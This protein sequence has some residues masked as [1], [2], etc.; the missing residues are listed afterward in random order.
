ML[1]CAICVGCAVGKTVIVDSATVMLA[2]VGNVLVV[3]LL[4]I[5]NGRSVIR[6]LVIVVVTAEVVVD[7]VVSSDDCGASGDVLLCVTDAVGTAMLVEVLSTLLDNWD[8]VV[9]ESRVE[10]AMLK[11]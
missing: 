10:L 7:K 3:L 5:G 2:N 4:L 11:E 1:E 9:A 8:H 6:G